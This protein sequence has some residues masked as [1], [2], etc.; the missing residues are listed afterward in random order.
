MSE[1]IVGMSWLTKALVAMVFMVPFMLSMSFFQKNY[2]M[3]GDMSIL[4]W[5]LGVCI[6]LI[7]LGLKS[8][9]YVEQGSRVIFPAIIVLL[10]GITIGTAGNYLLADSVISAPNPALPFTIINAASAF[11]YPLAVFLAWR[12][13][14]YFEASSFQWPQLAG[15]IMVIGGLA[16]LMY[17]K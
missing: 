6:G 1:Y 10:M 12:M 13:P 2:G 7:V 14:K 15:I 4:M 17:K 11:V 16:L 3:S 9:S 5:Q 8:G